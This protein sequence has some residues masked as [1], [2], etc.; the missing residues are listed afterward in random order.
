MAAFQGIVRRLRYGSPVIVVSGLPRSGT[1]M[2]MQMLAAGGVP[3]L[4]DGVRTPDDSN[5][6]GYFEYEPVKALDEGGDTAWVAEARGKAVKVVAPLL[7]HLPETSDYRVI[8]MQRQL[9]EVIAS[10]DTMLARAGESAGTLD[11][12]T[13]AAQYD[14]HLNKV[15]LVL[16]GRPCFVTL[17]V[18]HRDV[19]GDP[20]SAARRVADFL[21]RDLDVD[22]MTAA[23]RPALYRNRR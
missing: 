13:L 2:M 7:R 9:D 4:S 22:R 10:Q 8:F 11:P 6:E 20:A 16:N 14:A 21:E 15:R 3:I 19:V 18:A 5:P 23:V 17:D 1:S 12:T